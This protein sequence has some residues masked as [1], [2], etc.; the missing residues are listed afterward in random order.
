MAHEPIYIYNHDDDDWS[1]TGLVGDLRP[2]SCVYEEEKNGLSRITMELP[3]D[4]LGKYREAKVG[5]VIKCLV[6]VR[7]PPSID[8]SEYANT[9]ERY[10]VV[11]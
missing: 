8:D 10:R 11:E 9:S 5:R 7:L 2:I 4:S 6:P 3:Y 1:N